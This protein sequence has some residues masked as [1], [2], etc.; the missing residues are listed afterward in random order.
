M[1]DTVAPVH[2]TSFPRRAGEQTR[3]TVAPVVEGWWGVY[4]SSASELTVRYLEGRRAAMRHAESVGQALGRQ[5]WV[6]GQSQF[7]LQLS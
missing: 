1:H 5:G 7:V 4:T 6:R 2:T 3:C